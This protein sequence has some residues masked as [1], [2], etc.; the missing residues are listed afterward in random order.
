MRGGRR[1]RR[2]GDVYVWVVQI[3]LRRPYTFVVLSFLIA[4]FGGLAAVDA[5]R[6]FSEYQHTG[7]QRRLDLQRPLTQRYVRSRHLLL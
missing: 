3:A 4:I 6:H 7:G 2:H 5:D 1:S